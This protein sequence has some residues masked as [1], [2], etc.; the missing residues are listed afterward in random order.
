VRAVPRALPAGAAER[1]LASTC[2]V[3]VARAHLDALDQMGRK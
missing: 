1:A 3:A 2:D